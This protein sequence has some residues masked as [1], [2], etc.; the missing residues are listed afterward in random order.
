V[1]E[2]LRRAREPDIPQSFGKY[3]FRDLQSVKDELRDGRHKDAMT[4]S[5]QF[6]RIKER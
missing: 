5:S 4:G 3:K 1:E 2:T 6:A